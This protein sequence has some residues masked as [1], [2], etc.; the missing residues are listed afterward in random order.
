MAPKQSFSPKTWWYW[1]FGIALAVVMLLVGLASGDARLVFLGVALIF[2]AIG[3]I[4]WY[5]RLDSQDPG[6]STSN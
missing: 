3:L 2:L 4:A 6:G 5:R 1:R